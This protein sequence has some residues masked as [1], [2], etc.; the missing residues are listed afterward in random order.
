M[1]KILKKIA[2][3]D[4]VNAPF[5]AFTAMTAIGWAVCTAKFYEVHPNFWAWSISS[6]LMLIVFLI[7]GIF[8]HKDMKDEDTGYFYGIPQFVEI[9]GASMFFIW[10][11]KLNKFFIKSNDVEMAINIFTGIFICTAAIL[12]VSMIINVIFV[13]FDN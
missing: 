10:L 12:V 3:C 7:V 8:L 6:I 5:V 13:I 1:K 11:D 9:V 2:F 4:I